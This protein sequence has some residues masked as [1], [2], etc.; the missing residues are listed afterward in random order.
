MS[1]NTSDS[2][3]DSS[4]TSKGL[5]IF[6]ATIANIAAVTVG[7]DASDTVAIQCI[8]GRSIGKYFVFNGA[9][10][11]S[12]RYNGMRS[13]FQA[14]REIFVP[15]YVGRI[16]HLNLITADYDRLLTCVDRR[17]QALVAPAAQVGLGLHAIPAIPVN[18][19]L[20]EQMT[21]P[22]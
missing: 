11:L 6:A 12:A 4:A 7:V 20:V 17:F 2:A 22:V 10:Q 15:Q 18:H 8:G 3:N 5:G 21:L 9:V 13:A 16:H 19:Y 1:N 14:N